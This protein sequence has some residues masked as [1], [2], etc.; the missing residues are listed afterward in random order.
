MKHFLILTAIFASF[1]FV[2]QIPAQT[3]S[4]VN[5]ARG[6]SSAAVKGVVRGYEYRDY[7][8]RAN[9]GQTID[10]S[11]EASKISSVFTVFLPDGSNLE[12]AMQRNYFTGS[13]PVSG[14][15]VIRVGMMRAFARRKN[16]VSNYVLKIK[17]Y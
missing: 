11:S 4:R 2:D 3:K 13:L 6:S 16:S 14:D 9:A 10:I 1:C 17:V 7:V 5:F 8:V 12:A 15:Y